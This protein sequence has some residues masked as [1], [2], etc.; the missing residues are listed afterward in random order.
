MADLLISGFCPRLKL[1]SI[2]LN[3]ATRKLKQSVFISRRLKTVGCAF[4]FTVV[5]ARLLFFTAASRGYTDYQICCLRANLRRTTKI[6][7]GLIDEVRPG[8]ELLTV[9]EKV[10]AKNQVGGNRSIPSRI[11]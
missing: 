7:K 1:K 6:F 5:F 9:A 8:R 2:K 3:D 4:Q 11:S 10:D